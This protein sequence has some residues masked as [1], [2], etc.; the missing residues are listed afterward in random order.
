MESQFTHSLPGQE[1][2]GDDLNCIS[3]NAAL[4]DDR[5]LAELVRLLPF[6]GL[7]PVKGVIPYALNAPAGVTPDPTLALVG[8][9]GGA[10]GSSHVRPFRAIV[11]SR[12]S[13]GVDPKEHWRGIRSALCVGDVTLHRSVQ[14]AAT[15]AN[16]RW[17]LILAKVNVEMPESPVIRYVKDPSSENVAALSFAR[18]KSTSVSL[19]VVQGVEGASPLRPGIPNDAPPSYYIPLAYVYIAHPWT[20]ASTLDARAIHEV[21]P[22]VP[23]TSALGVPSIA[24]ANS[25]HTLAGAALGFNDWTS[26]SARPHAHLPPTMVGGVQR[27]IPLGTSG[28]HQT[29]TLNGI[30]VVDDSVDWRR[31]V[32]TCEVAFAS[33]GA[34]WAWEA[35]TGIVP[36]T[37]SQSNQHRLLSSSFRNDA[38]A[39][40]GVAGSIVI[41]LSQTVL[42]S[43]AA[44]STVM[45]FVRASD[46]ALCAWTNSTDPGGEYFFWLC[47]S[48]PFANVNQ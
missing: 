36:S 2:D 12:V 3:S 1:V 46:G 30:T 27:L 24:P 34:G 44:G 16:H 19:E 22:I 35:P 13:A 45:L 11:G 14:H 17:D 20:L 37:L 42:P 32:F 40:T 5:V 18:A 7:V 26:A 39:A 31:R 33:G 48:G 29:V 25:L 41:S 6:G 47:A 8:K 15:A 23:I 28:A 38:L 43:M 10:D 21:A 4:A 9:S